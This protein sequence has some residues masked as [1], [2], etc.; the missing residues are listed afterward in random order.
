LRLPGLLA[1]LRDHARQAGDAR[2]IETNLSTSNRP[3]YCQRE[4]DVM[5]LPVEACAI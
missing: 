5:G 4:M 1:V 2:F 3:H